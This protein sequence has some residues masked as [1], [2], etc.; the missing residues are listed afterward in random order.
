MALAGTR[1]S[2][3][4]RGGGGGGEEEEPW[5]GWREISGGVASAA[6]RGAAV[7]FVCPARARGGESSVAQIF[8]AGTVL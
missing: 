8:M 4:G 7:G 6:R 1:A 5:R 2:R 3:T